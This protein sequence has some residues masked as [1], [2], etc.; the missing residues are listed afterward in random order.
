MFDVQ[1]FHVKFQ[2]CTLQLRTPQI[3]TVRRSTAIFNG[4]HISN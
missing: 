1:I 4:W 3:Q 2:N